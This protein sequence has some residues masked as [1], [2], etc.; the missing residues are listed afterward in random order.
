MD[1]RSERDFPFLISAFGF[2]YGRTAF[3][4]T[5][6]A[7]DWRPGTEWPRELWVSIRFSPYSAF[8]TVGLFASE[9]HSDPR[10]REVSVISQ[11]GALSRNQRTLTRFLPLGYR[12]IIVED[13]GHG[14]GTPEWI[15]CETGFRELKA[16]A[17]FLRNREPAIHHPHGWKS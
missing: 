12:T 8:A 14:L 5:H 15:F 6:R 7:V 3:L 16:Q 4:G 17:G 2:E 9:H 13:S 10:S 11:N 1:Y